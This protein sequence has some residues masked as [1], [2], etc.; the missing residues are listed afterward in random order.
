MTQAPGR[1]V[2]GIGFATVADADEIIGLIKSCLVEA[3]A[4]PDDLVAIG[5]HARKLGT[6]VPLLVAAHFGVPLRLLDDRDLAMEGL[7][8]G[9]AAAAGPL[10]LRKRLSSYATC[11]L[12]LCGPTFRVERFGQPPIAKA[13]IASSTLATSWAG[14]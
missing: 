11:A 1:I 6:A 10:L 9:V 13:A 4:S 5:T 8:E 2:A 7:A 12:A 3:G 14:P